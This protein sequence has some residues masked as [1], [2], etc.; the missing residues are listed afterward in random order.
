[1]RGRGGALGYGAD[2]GGS[3]LRGRGGLA[4]AEL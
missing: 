2:G 1:M 4:L 3:S